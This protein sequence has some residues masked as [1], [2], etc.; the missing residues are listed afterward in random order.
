MT[1]P[2]DRL[3]SQGREF[4]CQFSLALSLDTAL[5]SPLFGIDRPAS[6]FQPSQG[7]HTGAF[8]LCHLP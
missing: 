5:F 7:T 3:A 4:G 8:E 6:K 1:I 2:I